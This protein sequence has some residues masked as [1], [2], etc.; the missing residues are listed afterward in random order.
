MKKKEM[1]G[2]RKGHCP[3]SLAEIWPAQAAPRPVVARP[4]SLLAPFRC[5]RAVARGFAIVGAHAQGGLFFSF[6]FDGLLCVCLFLRIAFGSAL[7][8]R[9]KERKNPGH[10]GGRGCH[11]SLSLCFSF[12]DV[13]GRRAPGRPQ[14]MGRRRRHC[15]RAP[16]AT[17]LCPRAATVTPEGGVCE[18]EGEGEKRDGNEGKQERP[19]RGID[20]EPC[21]CTRDG[22]KG[23][24]FR[25][26]TWSPF[27]STS[28]RPVPYWRT[29]PMMATTRPRPPSPLLCDSPRRRWPRGGCAR[30]QN[31]ALAKRPSPT[32]CPPRNRV[33]AAGCACASGQTRAPLARRRSSPS[34]RMRSAIR[35]NGAR[36]L[37]LPLLSRAS[38]CSIAF[39][40]RIERK[41]TRKKMLQKKVDDKVGSPF[42]PFVCA[43]GRPL[44]VRRRCRHFFVR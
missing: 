14:R 36:L 2:E 39:F 15:A 8:M 30:G 29:M 9:K 31:G 27:A 17:R 41:T 25:A 34:S 5:L 32:R 28:R 6:F 18:G 7:S 26:P 19:G 10:N 3:F 24:V 33:R 16:K 44:F 38:S 11:P 23:C 4:P 1:V 12:S 20:K 43:A 37:P 35:R 22:A 42:G 40:W 21:R 13:G